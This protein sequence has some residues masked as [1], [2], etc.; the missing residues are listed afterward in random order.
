MV[1]VKSLKPN[2][3][4][5]KHVFL[6]FGPRIIVLVLLSWTQSIHLFIG[7][8]GFYCFQSDPSSDMVPLPG[9]WSAG[10]NHGTIIQTC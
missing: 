6:Q 8:F 7:L 5:F 4:T 1:T 9:F 3:R 10:C 2:I